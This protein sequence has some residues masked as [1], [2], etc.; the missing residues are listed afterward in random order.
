MK[1]RFSQLYV[2]GYNRF[3][4]WSFL[5]IVISANTASTHYHF[6]AKMATAH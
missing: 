1:D 5:G 6:P 2:Y 3:N 4:Y